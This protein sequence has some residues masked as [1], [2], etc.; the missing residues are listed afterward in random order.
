MADNVQLEL[1]DYLSKRYANLKLRLTRMLGNGD[2]ASDA[3]H[4]T[5]LRLHGQ[6]EHGPIRSPGAYLVRMAHNI[7]V[8]VQRRQ[9]R[10]LSGE[11][12]DALLEEMCD[13]AP[14]P[15]QA[16]ESRSDLDALLK[17]MERMPE[18]RRLI[19]VMVHWEEATQKEAAARL[20]VSLRTVA[21][22]LK[23]AH[24]SLNAYLAAEKK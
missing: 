6:D 11:A 10:A 8:D 21:S 2:M 19:V 5:Y 18:R 4:D 1:L 17:V 23:R 7:A 12:I 9:R 15:E 13:P 14:G 3:L 24:E 16:A 22:E 20:G